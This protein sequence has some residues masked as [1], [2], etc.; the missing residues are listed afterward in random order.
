MG[1]YV[2][3]PFCA[4]K[5]RYCDFLSFPNDDH[6]AHA[7][8]ANQ[9]IMEL[10][11]KSVVYGNDFTVNTIFFGGGTPSLVDPSIIDEIADAVY[12]RFRVADD[13]EVSLE[14]NPGT[15]DENKLAAYRNAGVTRLSIGA[16]SF[17]SDTLKFLGRIHTERDT[18][19]TFA[20]A[21]DVGFENVNIDLI[22]GMPDET[23]E[24]WK[25]DI[26]TAVAMEPEHISFYSLQIEEGTPLFGD[27]E[28]GRF[29]TLSD[30]DDRRM[31]HAAIETLEGAGYVHY[32]ISNA[33]KPGFAS[34]HN[35]K[36]WSM[37]DYLGVGLGAHSYAGGRRFANTDVWNDYMGACDHDMM[38]TWSHKNSRGEDISEYV[39]LGLRKTEGI[40][41][42]QFRRH[43]GKDFWEIYNEETR[44][45][46]ERGLLEHSD[47][48]LRLTRLG[49]DLSNRVFSEYV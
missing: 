28:R 29:E 30:I 43:F 27:M 31:Y 16:Q 39:F 17:D 6:E 41:L 22:F 9:L 11:G 34:R 4:K 37:E 15:A 1:I 21:R 45:L 13:A 18:L 40:D 23:P 48:I 19:R 12:S 24:T 7:Y 3:L 44:M 38:T 46:M 20:L 8:Y 36:Y 2:H 35:L 49:L 5:C 33:A 47:G 10:V 32:E 25:R 26:E 14:V 42:E